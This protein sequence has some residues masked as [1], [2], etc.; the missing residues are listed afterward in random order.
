MSAL[1]ACCLLSFSTLSGF[2]TSAARAAVPVKPVTSKAQQTDWYTLRA[3][4]APVGSLRIQQQPGQVVLESRHHFRRDGAPYVVTAIATF[5]ES[6]DHQPEGFRYAFTWGDTAAG[7]LQPG[8]SPL[9]N[10]LT[11]TGTVAGNQLYI[12]RNSQSPDTTG[13]GF[14]PVSYQPSPPESSPDTGS[15]AIEPGRFYFP[16]GQ[17]L[18][19]LF[20]SHFDDTDGQAFAYETLHLGVTP[21]L[22]HT[23]ARP[24]RHYKT[25]RALGASHRLREFVLEAAGG[26]APAI[27]EWRSEKG[28]LMVASETAAPAME[29]TM[30]FASEMEVARQNTQSTPV[31]SVLGTQITTSIIPKPRATYHGVYV[32]MPLRQSGDLA[33]NDL[34]PANRDQQSAPVTQGGVS[35]L[36]LTV[37]P[38][39]PLDSLSPFPVKP[40]EANAA[41]LKPGPFIQSDDRRIRETARSLVGLPA[42]PLPG[43]PDEPQPAYAAMLKLQQWVLT[44]VEEKNLSQNFTSALDTFNNREGDCTEHAVL[45]AAMARSL[46]IPAR[47]AVGLVYVPVSRN[48][49]AVGKFQY[50]MWTEAW[51]GRDERGQWVGFDAT[52]SGSPMDATHLKMDD[53]ALAT[54]NDVERLSTRVAGGMG[55][56]RIQVE[57]ALA[58]GTSVVDLG[59]APANE[60]DTD[61]RNGAAATQAPWD[62]NRLAMQSRATIKTVDVTSDFG[63][64]VSPAHQFARALSLLYHPENPGNYAQAVTLL[65]KVGRDKTTGREQLTFARMLAGIEVYTLADQWLGLAE[66]SEPGLAGQVAVERQRLP[67]SPLP[68]ADEEKYLKARAYSVLRLPEDALA[69]LAEIQAAYPTFGPAWLLQADLL[70]QQDD[71]AGVTAAYQYY[72][73]IRPMDPAGYEHL[74]DWYLNR[75]DPRAALP[76]AE[77]AASLTAAQ[78]DPV[79]RQLRIR[80]QANVTLAIARI[81]LEE[82]PGRIQDWLNAGEALLAKGQSEDALAVYLQ[83]LKRQPRNRTAALRAFDLMLARNEWDLLKD[84]GLSLLAPS[85]GTAEGLTLR[86]AYDLKTRQYQA[87]AQKLQRALAMQPD[88]VRA[89]LLLATTRQRLGQPALA[90]RALREGAQ[91]VNGVAQTRLQLALA[92][93]LSDTT[94]AEAEAVLNAITVTPETSADLLAGQAALLGKVALR[95]NRPEDAEQRLETALSLSPGNA[96]ALYLLGQAAE[97]RDDPQLA[98]AYY[99]L[100]LAHDTD[101]GESQNALRSLIDQYQLSLKKPASH[102][103]PSED[104]FD[105]LVQWLQ[106][107]NRFARDYQYLSDAVLRLAEPQ[108]SLLTQQAAA[109]ALSE[110]LGRVNQRLT[111]YK[112]TLRTQAIQGDFAPFLQTALLDVET[113][114]QIL[115]QLALWMPNLTRFSSAEKRAAMKESIELWLPRLQ[116]TQHVMNTF[117][118]AMESHLPPATLKRLSAESGVS[119]MTAL[120]KRAHQPTRQLVSRLLSTPGETATQSPGGGLSAGANPTTVIPTTADGRVDPKW[121]QSLIPKSPSLP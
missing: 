14:H 35:G 85:L 49:L 71:T 40:T 119:S 100:A 70:K 12:T 55:N 105:F 67:A 89:T 3:N 111:A 118:L 91:R 58:N 10:R 86:A 15:I 29:M 60:P 76:Y 18:E 50:H 84:Q 30:S 64:V 53:S 22:C 77:Q 41:Y 99:Q 83:V 81:R 108:T 101:S 32:I 11:F 1:L 72:L 102:W 28:R 82:N 39:L 73:G 26:H 25:V 34:F 2:T 114:Q 75:D 106:E 112:N 46:G 6:P 44:H 68:P 107:T 33:L 92:R 38:Q 115:E 13:S 65:E 8:A 57:Q 36:R 61:T 45:L 56:I 117:A 5:E 51:I 24:T 104:E 98:L 17:R 120:L 4:G 110:Q 74:A 78:N 43:T 116:K 87:A 79:N 80:R 21:E 20:A 27:H 47:V 121:I 69:M 113:T 103:Q 94:P 7:A 52:Q 48:A 42:T 19:K 63:A 96:E 93:L 88:N 90:I 66:Q 37:N 31:D 23:V 95:Q 9:P 62:L 109:Q 54:L 59:D 16:A 97:R